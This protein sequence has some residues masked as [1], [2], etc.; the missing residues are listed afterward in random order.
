MAKGALSSGSQRDLRIDFFRGLALLFIFVD[1]VPDNVGA[2][3]TLRNFGFAD[4]AEVFVLLAGFSAVLAYGRTFESQG[5]KAGF[6][7]VLDRVREIYVWHLALLVVCGVGLTFAAS[8]FGNFAYM[9]NIGVHV[10][11]DDPTRSSVLAGLLVNQPNSLNILPLYIVLMLFWLP[12]VLW[13]LPRNPWQA[14]VLS[15]GLWAAANLVSVNLPSMQN[16][17]GWVFNPFAWQ[18]LITVGALTAHFYRRGE[19]RYSAPLMW[20]AIAYLTFAFLFVAPWT[21]VPGL[22]NAR[23][24]APDM[25]GNLDKTYLS[26]WRLANVV[27]LGYL[28]LI[29][30]SPQTGWLTRPM[31]RLVEDCGRYSLQIFCLGTVLSFAGWI[32]LV[33]TGYGLGLQILVNFIGIGILL[34]TA[35][36]LAS[37]GRG[38][39]WEFAQ[40]VRK[41]LVER[42][43]GSLQLPASLAHS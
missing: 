4:A 3:F 22:Q 14:L 21:Q 18:L 31:A 2:K 43:S 39:D 37:R 9:K 29:L 12:L 40:S 10:F 11:S 33:E 36:V 38:T 13:L 23:V 17:Q 7:R 5:F 41:A 27:A 15:L 6:S 16:P 25:L 28:V 1:H 34:G 24:F 19:I 8:Y 30:L 32:V 42:F 35:W 20:S 26:L